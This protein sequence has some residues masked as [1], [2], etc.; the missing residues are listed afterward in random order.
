M[1]FRTGALGVALLFC[2]SCGKKE[3]TGPDAAA[4]REHCARRDRSDDGRR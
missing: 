1:T 4:R 3:G 2:V